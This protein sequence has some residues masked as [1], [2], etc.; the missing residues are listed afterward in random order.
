MELALSS[1]AIRQGFGGLGVGLGRVG[2]VGVGGLGVGAW[3]LGFG[4]VW[5][6]SEDCS[7]VGGALP[8]VPVG[9]RLHASQRA[10]CRSTACTAQSSVRGNAKEQKTEPWREL[11]NHHGMM[12]GVMTNPCPPPNIESPSS[13]EG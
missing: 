9:R 11:G 10:R 8:C 3:A 2:W 4:G 12:I 6:V 5:G 1:K 13:R 7:C